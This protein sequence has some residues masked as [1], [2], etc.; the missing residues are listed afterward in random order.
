MLD[1][2]VVNLCSSKGLEVK[3]SNPERVG[4]RPRYL[5]AEIAKTMLHFKGQEA[6]YAAVVRDERSYSDEVFQKMVRIL[7]REALLPRGEIAAL[8]ALVADVAA[9]AATSVSLE[10][11]LGDIPAEFE[12]AML[13]TL[14]VRPPSGC[15]GLL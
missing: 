7:Q 14:M 2:L 12:D 1:L 4:F 8:Q 3:V 15:G 11:I 9:A 6:F 5:L 13:F 10:D